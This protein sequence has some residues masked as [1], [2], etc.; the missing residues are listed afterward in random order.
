MA[1][2]TN[3]RM[4]TKIASNQ[5]LEL[6]NCLRFIWITSG[7]KYEPVLCAQGRNAC[8]LEKE[9]SGILHLFA[10]SFVFLRTARAQSF[11]R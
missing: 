8:G 6:K 9:A 11:A 1:L 4:Q 10:V 7:E 2:P 5:A 3:I